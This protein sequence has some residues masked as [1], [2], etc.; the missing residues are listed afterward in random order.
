MTTITLE[1]HEAKLLR[2]LLVGYIG[3]KEFEYLEM[4]TEAKIA[5]DPLTKFY[6][7]NGKAQLIR[8]SDLL[9]K[10]KS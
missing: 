6:A 5:R 8:V 4:E 9:N 7:D 10:L 1:Q 3:Q 2:S